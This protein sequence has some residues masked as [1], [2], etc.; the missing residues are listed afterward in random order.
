M[1]AAP[2]R[3]LI[4]LSCFDVCCDFLQKVYLRGGL[5]QSGHTGSGPTV[6][7]RS[8][9]AKADRCRLRVIGEVVMAVLR[10]IH[11]NG[12]AMMRF[13]LIRR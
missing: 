8:L 13:V 7:K 1:R 12:R 2:P 3:T 11:H 10:R 5:L 6:L 9:R 4:A